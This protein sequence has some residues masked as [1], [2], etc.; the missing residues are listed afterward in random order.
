MKKIYANLMALAA[1][2]LLVPTAFAQ[3]DETYISQKG[4][5][6]N[7]Y[8]KNTEPN[9]DGEYILRLETFLTGSVSK[10][11][12]PT[13]FVLTLD[14]SGS[15]IYDCLYGAS[16]P[17]KVTAAQ[18][19]DSNSPYYEF[20]RPAHKAGNITAGLN[21]YTYGHGYSA[22]TIGQEM[23]GTGNGYCVW[24]Y[25]HYEGTDQGPSLY[26][27]YE[28]DQTYYK[29]KRDK[30]GNYCR[31]Y[32]TR[33][34]GE[35]RYVI[36]TQSGSTITTTTSTTPPQSTNNNSENKILLIGYEGDNIYRPIQRAE[37]LN[38]GV[39]AF[40]EEIAYHNS[41]DNFAAGVTKNQVAV[42]AFGSGFSGGSVSNPSITPT[43]EVGSGTR[44]IRD[45]AEINSTNVSDYESVVSNS[46]GFR[47]STYVFYGVRLAKLLLQ[48][49][50]TKTGM[51]PLNAQ[52]GTNRNKV[53]VVFTDGEPSELNSSGGTNGT[54]NRFN[55]VKLTLDEANIVKKVRT[56]VSGTEINAKIFTIDLASN[57]DQQKFL[58]RL[59]S[60]YLT[61]TATS[62]TTMNTIQYSGSP[63]TPATDRIFYLNADEE[64]GLEKAF[65]S[66]VD[67]NT[68]NT[69][70]HM[71]AVDVINDSF[72]LPEGVEASGKIKLF[73]A[74]CVGSKEI[75]GHTYLAFTDEVPVDER[76]ALEEIW[77]NSTNDAGQTV[78]AKQTN[79]DIDSDIEAV[80]D[81]ETKTLIFKGFDF[82]NLW[83]GTDNDPDH[84][85][86]QQIS[87]G[88]KNYDIRDPQYRGFKLIAEFPIVVTEDAVGGP[89][90]PTNKVDLSGLF[91]TDESG[92][93]TDPIINY[94]EPSLPIPIKLIIQK[95]GLLQGESASFTIERKLASSTTATWTEF[96]TFVLTGN[97]TATDIPEI[98]FISLDPR[99]HYRVKESG[100]SWAYENADPS[101]VP[102]TE[103]GITNPIVFENDPQDG[104]KHAEAKAVNK[105]RKTASQTITVY[106]KTK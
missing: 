90:V 89:N 32:F 98:R 77:Y 66:I 7:K 3:S 81:E 87:S 88:M 31:L 33:T 16:R 24:G 103:T 57:A 20:L 70:E 6:Y 40:I 36:C 86:T 15:M 42:I 13:D 44:V 105:M 64:D 35:K 23:S 4:V 2:F 68:G 9:E 104:P 21:H 47:G 94:P 91:Q 27:Y 26:Y 106:D 79:I 67:A 50:Q 95:T 74:Q 22:G 10:T 101:F 11:A 51:A 25:F 18:M 46:F 1:A 71:V 49:L 96:T 76:L 75:N 85:N 84:N 43:D 78:W 48:N 58:E 59:S 53:V 63:I 38:D 8:L 41:H 72:A 52:G 97:E 28:Q 102:S 12:I 29:I 45:F 73:T 54:T 17:E 19:Q 34:G 62:G 61:A 80:V 30:S 65:R 99:Y 82:G 14:C 92:N 37:A 60:N 39:N 83:C 93:P 55:N 5:G 100:W 69:S 56:Q